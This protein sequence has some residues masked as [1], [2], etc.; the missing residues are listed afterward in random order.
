MQ[1]HPGLDVFASAPVDAFLGRLQV[2]APGVAP[3]PFADESI[4]D[5]DLLLTWL[6]SPGKA[7]IENLFIRST[8]QGADGELLVTHSEESCAACIEESRIFRADKV[9]V[10]EPAFGV[11]PDFVQH[12][13]E[14]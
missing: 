2:G 13:G 4:P 7:P 12:S 8:L 14:I 6:A 9:S 3:T 5:F 10:L 1:V 11:E